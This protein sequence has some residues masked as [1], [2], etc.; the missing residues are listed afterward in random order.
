MSKEKKFIRKFKDIKTLPHVVT[1]LSRLIAD[2]NSTMKDF[3]DVIKMDPILVVRLLR[4]VNS[5]FYGLVQRVD[6]I[7]RAVAYLGMKNLHNLAVTD[8]LK[9]IF[10][11][12]GKSDSF[13][14]EKLWLHCAAVSICAKMIAE[15]IF[16]TN[17]DDAYLCGILHDFGLI[18][19]S[20]VD[21]D[22]FL[23][24]CEA[25]QDGDSLTQHEQ[26]HLGTD[27]CK[28]GYLLS[29]D[30]E[31]PEPIQ[32]AI[33]DHHLESGEYEPSSLTGII[34]IAEY[35]T[36]QLGYTALTDI[37]QQLPSHLVAHMQENMDEYKVLIDDLPEEMSNAQE[38]YGG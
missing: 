37:T 16:E 28:I 1:N 2:D 6:S 33:R 19:E 32:E 5:P 38:L 18:V 34:Q 20:Q 23:A 35:I 24:A 9:N 8:A 22:N 14:K 25:C 13:S 10:Q 27:H 11:Q 12:Q 15:R 21:Q 26:E 7:G 31:M 17:G 4:L 36:G 29:I 3:E 30:W